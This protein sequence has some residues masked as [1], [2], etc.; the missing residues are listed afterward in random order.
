MRMNSVADLRHLEAVFSFA[1]AGMLRLAND[2]PLGQCLAAGKIASHPA[3]VRVG[4]RL[5]HEGGA[6]VGSDWAAPA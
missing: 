1:P 4:P 6:D 5:A 3:L 2:F